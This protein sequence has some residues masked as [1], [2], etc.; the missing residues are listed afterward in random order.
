MNIDKLKISEEYFL[1]LYPKGFKDPEI[2]K[3]IKRHNIDK[4]VATTKELLKEE[5]FYN[6]EVVIEN[7]IKIIGRAS[8]VSLFEKPKFRDGL[9]SLSMEGKELFALGLKNLIYGNKKSGF[10]LLNEI[11][12]P[13]KLAKW[14]IYTT[15]LIYTDPKKEV[16]VKP[17]TAKNI[18][19]HFEVENLT[20]KSQPSFEFYR[21]YKKLIREMKKHV[22]RSLYPNNPAFTG[23]LM[24]SLEDKR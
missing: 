23:F 14:S 15:F 7:A 9:Q 6:P 18:I 19:K 2:E 24:M 17:T 20:Y 4:H 13:L 11:L 3:I 16:F 21:G 5:N 12:A 10:E 1:E 8:M 22:R